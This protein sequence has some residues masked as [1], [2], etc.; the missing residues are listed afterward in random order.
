MSDMD[1]GLMEVY[2]V[3]HTPK[4]EDGND[5]DFVCDIKHIFCWFPL[6]GWYVACYTAPKY[7]V[8]YF[9]DRPYEF[10]C[11]RRKLQWKDKMSLEVALSLISKGAEL[12]MPGEMENTGE[13]WAHNFK[14]DY[15]AEELYRTIRERVKA[16]AHA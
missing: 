7:F 11:S 2:R 3:E 14:K 12:D 13:Y 9:P 10:V 8:A 5:F 16:N 1:P 15:E 6:M 4:F